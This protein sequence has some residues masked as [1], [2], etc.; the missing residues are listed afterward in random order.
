MR[1]LLV[2]AFLSPV[3]SP[4]LVALLVAACG[5]DRP[6]EERP[7]AAVLPTE[8]VVDV[9]PLDAEPP[10]PPDVVEEVQPVP[11]NGAPVDTDEDVGTEPAEDVDPSETAT[12]DVG[13][14]P[15]TPL[16]WSCDDGTVI[17]LALVCDDWE[18]CPDGSDEA[19]DVCPD[20]NC[21]DDSDVIP[22][23]WVCDMDEDCDDGSDELG[24]ET[25]VCDGGQTE[26]P[27]RWVC[28]GDL[29]CVDETDERVPG[30][31][32]FFCEDG[33]GT[34]PVHQVCDGRERCDDGSDERGCE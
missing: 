25:F 30:C 16:E 14:E 31:T 32:T 1:R 34:L 13:G 2:P 23:G 8:D 9:E 28:D 18:D 22:G 19:G 26:I 12:G 3:L 11:D 20:F 4:V 21:S 17:P 15:V 29:D 10:G 24:C 5:G 27:N 7:D 6:G 33:S